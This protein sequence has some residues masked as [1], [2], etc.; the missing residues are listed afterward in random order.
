MVPNRVH[1]PLVGH[2][3]SSTLRRNPLA[4][5][6]RRMLVSEC[7]RPRVIHWPFLPLPPRRVVN[8]LQ[9][10]R[11]AWTLVVPRLPRLVSGCPSR[12]FL[13][14]PLRRPRLRPRNGLGL[15]IPTAIQPRGFRLCEKRRVPSC[16]IHCV[17]LLAS[18]RPRQLPCHAP[19]C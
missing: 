3:G 16:T 11:S 13:G 5:Y 17:P 14:Q 10:L 15:T 1:L 18:R 9:M 4:L 8:Q 19:L 7:L 2:R 12:L 6:I